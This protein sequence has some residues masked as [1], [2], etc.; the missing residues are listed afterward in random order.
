M[1]QTL[2]AEISGSVNGPASEIYLA[3]I[4]PHI[5][6]LW[7]APPPYDMVRADVDARVR[8][9]YRHEV[10]G[11]DGD[12]LVTGEY[13]ETEPGRHI[14]KSWKYSGPNPVP[15]REAT[16]VRVDLVDQSD[17]TTRITIRHEGL[18][19]PTE[20]KHYQDGW[21]ECLRRLRELRAEK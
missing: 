13:L 4:D 16:F 21:G 7:L 2:I 8:G 11:P 10:T 19:D 1:S 3:W 12:H 14:L 18:R 9:H 17:G 6:P 5:L 20:V 15:S